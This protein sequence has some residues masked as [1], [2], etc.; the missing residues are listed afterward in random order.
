MIGPGSTSNASDEGRKIRVPTMSDP[1]QGRE[2]QRLA[3]ARRA[4]E[5][6]VPLRQ[7]GDEE[8]IDDP[9]LADDDPA[10]LMTDL[11]KASGR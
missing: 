11:G 10:Q 8:P 5:Q 9:I 6:D 1:R 7:H 2:E 3:Q 4:F